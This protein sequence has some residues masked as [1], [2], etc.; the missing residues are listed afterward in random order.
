[1]TTAYFR[2]TLPN[3]PVIVLGRSIKFDLLATQDVELMAAL[4]RMA[5]E[6]R[7]GV[8]EIKQP[9]FDELTL[10]KKNSPPS[11]MRPVGREEFVRSP[12]PMRQGKNRGVAESVEAAGADPMASEPGGVVELVLPKIGRM[13]DL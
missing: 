9:E 4:R 10:K 1:M 12:F 5:V 13:S 6:G 11:S 2:K 3:N 7:G 8:I